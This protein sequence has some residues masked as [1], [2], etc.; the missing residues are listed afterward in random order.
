MICPDS[1]HRR[2]IPLYEAGLLSPEESRQMESHILECPVC[3]HDLYEMQPVI[4]VIGEMGSPFEEATGRLTVG[5]FIRRHW[6]AVAAAATVAVMAFTLYFLYLPQLDWHASPPP[7]A[8]IHRILQDMSRHVREAYPPVTNGPDLRQSAAAYQAGR[9]AESLAAAQAVLRQD[10]RNSAA[11]LLVVRCH[12]A[13]DQPDQA[14]A[15]LA[16][17][18]FGPDQPDYADHLWLQ[19]EALLRLQKPDAAVP[20]LQLLAAQPGPYQAPSRQLLRLLDT[21]PTP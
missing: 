13:L 10:D 3:A 1:R 6:M 21:S 14:L 19:S 12:L 15:V 16:A 18:P 11:V 8:D 17:H 4:E 2:R 9:Y 5:Q 7:T 20:L